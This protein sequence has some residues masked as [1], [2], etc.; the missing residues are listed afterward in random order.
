[1]LV[2][3]QPR[4]TQIS[5]PRRMALTVRLSSTAMARSGRR[6]G[7]LLGRISGAARNAWA[8]SVP[9]GPCLIGEGRICAPAT[10]PLRS[11]RDAGGSPRRPLERGR[12]LCLFLILNYTQ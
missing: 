5:V 1:M 4:K 12:D 8:G 9:R 3:V 7:I 6:F 10:E 11:R 2:I